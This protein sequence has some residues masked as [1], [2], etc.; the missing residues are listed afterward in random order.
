[1]AKYTSTPT[2]KFNFNLGEGPVW[3]PITQ[4]LSM[5]DI[6]ERRVHLFELHDTQLIHVDEFAT[7][8]DVGAALPLA[9]GGFVLCEQNGVFV[10][11]A[12]GARTK[13]CDLPVAEADLRFNDGKLG[14]DGKLWVGIMDYSATEGRGSLWRI[15]RD[16]STELLLDG[17]TIPNGLDWWHDEF[18]FVNGPA[19]EIRCYRWD[20]AGLVDSGRKV[21][22]NGTPDGLAIDA[23]GELWLALWGEGRVD[24]FDHSGAVVDS[25]TVASPHS[26]SLCFAGPELDTVVMTSA[27]FNMTA[28]AIA[29]HE[30]AGD[31]FVQAVPVRGRPPHL[32]FG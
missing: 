6:F 19:E 25:I 11:S 5:V 9:E 24:H 13:V 15:A 7:E 2:G 22:T 1:M 20:E 29:E 30:R 16:G 26:T 3:N 12:A 27:Q 4:K 31:I 17:L 23:S 18:W 8:G 14:P 10:R 32:H 21:L 28:A